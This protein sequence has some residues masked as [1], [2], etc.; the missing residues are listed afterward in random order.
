MA[1]N[2]TEVSLECCKSQTRFV[3]PRHSNTGQHDGFKQSPQTFSRGNLSRSRTSVRKP[4]RAQNAAQ[5]DPAGP[6]PTIATSKI[7]ILDRLVISD[8]YVSVHRSPI[9]DHMYHCD[10][11]AGRI[12]LARD[13]ITED[14][15][16]N[17]LVSPNLPHRGHS[18]AD[19]HYVLTADCLA[20]FRL[21]RAGRFGG[22]GQPRDIC[23]A[24]FPLRGAA[25]IRPRVR[26]EGVR[27][28]Y[29]RH[30]IT[31]DRRSGAP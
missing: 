20:G 16:S 29:A 17:E 9:T 30:H 10:V 14:S 15:S 6:P 5:L 23:F 12:L 28:Q 1:T 19:S 24:S 8:Q 3:R 11:H 21:L 26:C 2:S 27:D 18:I 4:A 25:R 7:S 22:G 13:L 31:A